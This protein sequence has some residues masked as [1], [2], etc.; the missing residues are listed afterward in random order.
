MLLKK[1][2]K[3]QIMSF[4]RSEEDQNVIFWMETFFKIWRVEKF[5]NQNQTRF[6]SIQNLTRCK[7]F[8]SKTDAL[9]KF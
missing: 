8:K 9:W 3:L 1:A 2:R 4:S 5:L 6:F 7:N